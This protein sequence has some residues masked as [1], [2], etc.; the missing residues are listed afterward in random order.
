[1]KNNR[2]FFQI[3]GLVIFTIVIVL[4]TAVHHVL[5]GNIPAKA[6]VE[7]GQVTK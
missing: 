6:D 3:F 7:K 5:T 4:A 1:M 2:G